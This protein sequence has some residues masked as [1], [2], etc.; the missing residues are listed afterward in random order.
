MASFSNDHYYKVGFASAFLGSHT[1]PYQSLL[2]STTVLNDYV[3]LCN[4]QKQH[5]SLEIFRHK[6]VENVINHYWKFALLYWI[7][8]RIFYLLSTLVLTAFTVNLPHPKGD[9]CKE[10]FNFSMFIILL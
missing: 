2:L 6:L 8:L 3:V 9:I 10:M 4:S 7:V 1:F 5:G